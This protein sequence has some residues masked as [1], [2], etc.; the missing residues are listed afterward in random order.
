ME[1]G[2]LLHPCPGPEPPPASFPL[3]R[4]VTPTVRP[5]PVMGACTALGVRE[6]CRGSL[7]GCPSQT[8]PGPPGQQGGLRSWRG[9]RKALTVTSRILPGFPSWPRRRPFPA[10]P[11]LGGRCR[12]RCD[13]RALGWPPAVTGVG[14]FLC[15]GFT[16]AG[17]RPSETVKTFLAGCPDFARGGFHGGNFQILK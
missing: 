4:P 14:C 5:D 17:S 9:R 6:P 10:L 16:E 3:V 11:H 7:R 13:L 1:P 12:T 2:P 15:R 8:T